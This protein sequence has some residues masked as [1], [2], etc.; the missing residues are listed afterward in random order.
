[1][2]LPALS[3]ERSTKSDSRH[4]VNGGRATSALVFGI[5]ARAYS[6]HGRPSNGTARMIPKCR[7]HQMNSTHPEALSRLGTP[8]ICQGWMVGGCPRPG[9]HLLLASCCSKYNNI[10]VVRRSAAASYLTLPMW[11]SFIQA[12]GRAII[13][14]SI[15]FLSRC[16]PCM[17]VDS[18]SLAG[19]IATPLPQ[20][21]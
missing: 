1:M 13:A 7:H 14:S 9:N 11:T 8:A 19:V 4:N 15:L 17:H 21:P 12:V 5:Y 10:T 2:H 3:W 6:G 18:L 16:W 20:T